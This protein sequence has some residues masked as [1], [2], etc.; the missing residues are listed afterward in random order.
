WP[1]RCGWRFPMTSAKDLTSDRYEAQS[2]DDAI[3]LCY[4][5]GWTAGLPVV[6]PTEDKVAR[7]LDAAGRQPS[8][9]LGVVPIRGRVIT[10]EKV[11]INAVMAGCLPEYMPVL[12]AAVDAI[13]DEL[14]NPH[15]SSASTGGS[16]C[17][18]L[19]NGP[20]R[21]QLG[22]NSQSNVFGPGPAFRAN[23]TI[24]RA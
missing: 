1:E 8:D 10:A 9:V 16:A 5:R 4:R 12:V 21:H 20:I 7:F 6:P 3:E 17:L 24:G 11:A 19:V 13:C 15:G 2:L 14:Y 18:M 23:A 22:L